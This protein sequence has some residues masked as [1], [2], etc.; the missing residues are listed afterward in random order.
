M[1]SLSNNAINSRSMNGLINVS[2]N[3]GVFD[4]IDCNT[5]NIAV[6]GNSPT[7]PL[8]DNSTRIATTAW[9]TNHAVVGFVTI[10]TTQN[11]TGQ[12]TFSNANTLISGNL[13]T[14]NIRS[15]LATTDIS[16]GSNLTTGDIFL[17]TSVSTNVALNWGT[18]SN[19]GQLFFQGGSFNFASTGNYL[20]RSGA[21]FVT[22]IDST[23]TTGQ[24]LIANGNSQTGTISIGNGTGIKI[25]NL[26][27]TATTLNLVGSS[28]NCNSVLPQSSLVP[29]LGNQLT[30]KNY[31]DGVISGGSFVT[32]NTTQTITGAKTFSTNTLT[33][34]AGITIK[35]GVSSQTATLTQNATTFDVIGVGDVSIKPT[36]D[37]N[38]LT[39]IG[40][41]ITLSNPDS[42]LLP[43][44]T[45]LTTGILNNSSYIALESPTIYITGLSTQPNLII[46]GGF[47]TNFGLKFTRGGTALAAINRINCSSTNDTLH[48]EINSGQNIT[49]TD[50]AISFDVNSTFNLVPT[51][52][53][54]MHPSAT[55]PSG[56][57]LCDG[58]S[59]T[60]SGIFAKLFAVIGYTY[61][62]AGS[63]F[64]KPNFQG[65]FI[66]GAGS[67]TA[68]GVTYTSASVGTI[69]QDA[70]LNPLF[71]SNEGF[72]S[73]AAGARDCVSRSII[74]SDPT[75]TNTGILPRFD[76]T[77]TENRPV[78]H[79]INYYIRF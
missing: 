64:N 41:N 53:I 10:N 20:Q 56:Y 54:I 52:T 50:T 5:I 13:I 40:K 31:V 46:A 71:A 24:T 26:G 32:T 37:F 34:S 51:G 25:M 30:N 74:T 72:R 22:N 57:L 3:S 43:S 66:R 58:T 45:T 29:T 76:R 59:V 75:D 9:V 12:K 79:A 62:G 61:G 47:G 18:S 70:V 44:E 49:L 4:D 73:C 48:I 16:I 77:A 63:F 11:I 2:A 35:N 19:T 42:A 55:A 8:L 65:C 15:A 33:A 60:T 78:N 27:G 69:Q 23:K 17:A 67:Q 7:P 14:N 28:I 6:Q 39:G 36:N 38:V 1:S 68:G 21:V